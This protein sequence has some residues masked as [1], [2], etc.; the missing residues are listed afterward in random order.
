MRKAYDGARHLKKGDGVLCKGC[1]AR[2]AWID[3]HKALWS[4]SAMCHVLSVSKSGYYASKR[5]TSSE[6]AQL[7]EQEQAAL[8][9]AIKEQCKRHKQ[10]YGR[11]RMTDQLQKLGFA[12]N[13][14]RVGKEMKRMDLQCKLRRKF[15][16]CTT[17]SK[18]EYG[19]AP[20]SLNR[21][22][23]QVAPNKAWV[24]DITYIHT[25]EGWLFAALVMDLFS[26]KIVGW[27]L[28]SEMP[29]ALTTEALR[30]ALL[31]R[32]PARGLIHHS[33]RG[34]Q[35]AAH[36]YRDITAL[37]GMETS[38]SR[39]GN[40]WDNAAMESVNGTLKVEC[41]NR[42]KYATREQ[43][44]CDVLEFI[45]YYNHDRAHSTLGNQTPAQ[46]EQAW[47][48]K[49]ASIVHQCED[50]EA[51]PLGSNLLGEQPSIRYLWCP[52]FGDRFT[53]AYFAK[54]YF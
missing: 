42:E 36:D 28:D 39:R 4:V 46:F 38:M 49:Q 5:R 45:G 19:I 22:F 43:A 8:C 31:G 51:L 34:S 9:A 35:Y 20:N 14:K 16:I 12:V 40:C 37:C 54:W 30:T 44:R 24:A 18:H 23:T 53:A 6:A 29:Q 13:H 25:A 52:H 48:E 15:K 50:K 27:A 7:K 11:P 47:L 2:Y 26:K 10:R 33:D 32:Q 21:Q 17:D 1:V 3:E 41:V